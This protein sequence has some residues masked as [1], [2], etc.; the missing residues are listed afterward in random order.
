MTARASPPEIDLSAAVWTLT[1][2]RP[3]AWRLRLAPGTDGFLAPD[4]GP[5]PAR[6]PGSVQ[7]NLL[8]ADAVPDWTTG[9]NSLAIEWL[10]HR[11]WMFATHIEG[12][13]PGPA[14]RL[15][16]HGESLDYSGWLLIDGAVVAEFRGPHQ[17][18]EIDVTPHLG[19]PGRHELALVFDGPPEVPGQLGQTSRARDF[20]PRYNFGWD[21]CVRVVPV[22]AAG[23]LA[24]EPRCIPS[25]TLLAVSSALTADLAE[26]EVCVRLAVA[27]ASEHPAARLTISYGG[28]PV[29]TTELTLRAG[30]NRVTACLPRPEIWWPNGLGAQPLYTV[31]I[32]A[33]QRGQRLRSWTREI[34]FKHIDWRNCLGAPAAALPWICAINGQAVFLQ[35]VNW[36]PSRLCYQDNTAEEIAELVAIYREMGCNL[37]RVWGGAGLESPAFYAACDRAGVLVWQEFPL[38]SSGADSLP[39]SDPAFVDTLCTLARHF[40]RARQH[41]ACLLQWCGGNELHDT[42][43]TPA[44]RTRIPLTEAHPALSALAALVAE[45][46]PYHRFLPTSPYGPRFHSTPA[47]FG[48]GLHHNVHGPWSRDEFPNR[49]AWAGYWRDDDALF[50]A[51]TGIPA[52]SHVATITDHAANEPVW[53]PDTPLWRHSSGWWTQWRRL[54]SEFQGVAGASALARY[55]ALTQEE[56][57]EFLAIAAAETKAKF[58]RCGGFLIWMGHDAFPCLANTSLIDF[59]GRPKPAVAALRAVFRGPKPE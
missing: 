27:A 30:E 56:Q 29:A 32:E 39:P 35:G 51:E 7:E 31:T 5:F 24:I 54:E 26:G 20:K 57:A 34:G 36:T 48:R 23:R 41:H 50:R 42:A 47:E 43:N 21:W 33:F 12:G 17:P 59:A 38:S 28:A 45:E 9:L 11:H 40:V 2:W 16:F 22:G 46:D 25:V 49:A 15:I 6:L 4:H 55:V 3:H 8:R 19:S 44:G 13:T 18:T 52:A 14:S 58:P 53:P 1:G 10:E 37:L